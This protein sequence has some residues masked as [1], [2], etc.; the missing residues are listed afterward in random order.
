MFTNTFFEVLT[1]N[2]RV[3]VVIIVCAIAVDLL[4]NTLTALMRGLLTSNDDALADANTNVFADVMTA[5]EFGM[6]GPSL[7][8]F[9]C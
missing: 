7:E 8:E 1:V 5:F 6:P 3:D 9:R 4:M 2:I